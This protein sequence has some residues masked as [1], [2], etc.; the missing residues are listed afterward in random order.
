MSGCL[1]LQENSSSN[2]LFKMYTANKIIRKYRPVSDDCVNCD[3]YIEKDFLEISIPSYRCKH[4]TQG[5]CIMC[6]YGIGTASNHDNNRILNQIKGYLSNVSTSIHTILLSTNGSILDENS[7]PRPLLVEV[8]EVVNQ[9]DATVIIVETHLD[10]LNEERIQHLR[11]YVPYKELI[12]E[13]GLE[14]ID[15][16]VQKHCYLKTI[17]TRHIDNVFFLAEQYHIL[18]QFNIILGAPFLN[19]NEQIEDAENSIRWVLSHGSLVT[20]FPMNVKPFT[21]LSFAYEV[22][23]YYPISHWDLLILLSKF[24]SDQLERIDLAWYGNRENIYE[25]SAT[26][27]PTDCAECHSLLQDFYYA[28]N[29]S[30]GCTRYNAV[31]KTLGAN[32]CYCLKKEEELIRSSSCVENRNEIV[33]STQ[34]LL[35]DLFEKSKY[36]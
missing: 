32:R 8:L 7:V 11:H 14:T 35:I 1:C 19:R 20:L 26:V 2:I 6:N 12:L 10:T 3:F 5:G 29:R 33:K 18:I 27:F 15:P 25:R 17:S 31:R 28:Y 13:I 21:L 22:G 34:S 4:D 9:S 30:D 16:F 23:I 24:N 36:I